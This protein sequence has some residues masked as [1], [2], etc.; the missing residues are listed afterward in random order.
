MTVEHLPAVE[1]RARLHGLSLYP[2]QRVGVERL[3]DETTF[4]LSDDMGLGKTVQIVVA[5]PPGS[6]GMI[7]CPSGVKYEWAKAFKTWR[8]EFR[9]RVFEGKKEFRQ[10]RPGEVVILNYEIMPVSSYEL[11]DAH[12]ELLDATGIEVPNLAA[13]KF[14]NGPERARIYQCLAKGNANSTHPHQWAKLNKLLHERRLLTAPHPGTI[15]AV[16]EAQRAKNPSA[17]ATRRLRD[18]ANLALASGGRVWTASATPLKN[19]LDELWTVLQ[20]NGLGTRAFGSRG[21][22]DIDAARPNAIAEKLRT[23]SLRRNLD[24]VL[25]DLPE[26]TWESIECPLDADTSRLAD[27]VVLGLRAVGVEIETATLESI[28]SATMKSI[29]REMWSRLRAQLAAAKV[30]TLLDLVQDLESAGEGSVVFCDHRAPL[31]VL[32][33]REGWEKITSDEDGP[34]KQAVKERAQAGELKGVGVGIRAGGVGITLTRFRRGIWVDL[35]TVPADLDQGAARLRRIGQ[36]A[37]GI[38][39]TRLVA[40]HVLERRIDSLLERKRKLFD[41]TVGASAVPAP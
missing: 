41:S 14:W 7:I 37:K 23:I 38:L 36:M 26:A 24:D 22:F 2:F 6:P 27:Q 5:F 11:T 29:P 10:P 31:R 12:A 32:C 3:Y 19:N 1:A 20:A 18:I 16:D 35:P 21:Q 15:V 8:P 17:Q 33:Q 39:H 25:P 28:N 30:P 9:T 13:K 40:A 4:L 34:E